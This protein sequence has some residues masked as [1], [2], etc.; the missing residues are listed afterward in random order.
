MIA[1]ADGP[2]GQALC[3][4]ALSSGDTVVSVTASETAGP[5]RERLHRVPWSTRSPLAPR[6]IMLKAL[7]VVPRIDR[8]IVVHEP[9]IEAHVLADSRLYR[10]EEAIDVWIKGFVMLTRELVR[11]FHAPPPGRERPDGALALVAVT[12][13]GE[14]TESP[15]VAVVRDGFRGLMRSVG[16]DDEAGI[17]VASFEGSDND[18]AAF[19][20]YVLKVVGDRKSGHRRFGRRGLLSGLLGS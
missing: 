2:C 15:L 6:S 20:G 7:T 8:A 5:G 13:S 10:V 17:P 4:A 16:G 12:P 18:L 11:Y 1:G 9:E 3:D 14:S 19:A